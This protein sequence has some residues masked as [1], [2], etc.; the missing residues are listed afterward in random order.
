MMTKDERLARRIVKV[1]A[2]IDRIWGHDP[3]F[4][5][6]DAELLVTLLRARL[7]DIKTDA[8]FEQLHERDMLE[9]EVK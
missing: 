2:R 3:A 8:L 1:S 5:L 6:M 7:D 4:A 9:L